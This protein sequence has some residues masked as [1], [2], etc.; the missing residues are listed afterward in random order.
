MAGFTNALRA[1]NFDTEQFNKAQR[2]DLLSGLRLGW[3][4]PIYKKK[5][6]GFHYY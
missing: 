1:F 6:T 5:D 4:L 3:S 2:F